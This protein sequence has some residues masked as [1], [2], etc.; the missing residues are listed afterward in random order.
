V[1][2]FPASAGGAT[3]VMTAPSEVEKKQ[4]DELGIEVKKNEN[5]KEKNK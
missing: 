1:I 2:P 4:L 3:S 5:S